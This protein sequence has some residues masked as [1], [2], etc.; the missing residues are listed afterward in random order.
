MTT[1]EAKLYNVE[2]VR[3]T[4]SMGV[5]MY[6]MCMLAF[7]SC[8]GLGAHFV[9]FLLAFLSAIACPVHGRL[10]SFF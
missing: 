6:R 3:H 8:I 1:V 10:I 4:R 5:A 2:D 9:S 7:N